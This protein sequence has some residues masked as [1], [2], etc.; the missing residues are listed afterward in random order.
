VVVWLRGIAQDPS[1]LLSEEGRAERAVLNRKQVECVV[2]AFAP[3]AIPAPRWYEAPAPGGEKY[4]VGVAFAASTLAS[5]VEVVGKHPY[6]ERIELDFGEAQR[7]N[8]AVPT[9]FGGCARRVDSVDPKLSK[10]VE[11]ESGGRKPVSVGYATD[12]LPIA[13]MCEGGGYACET[14]VS[15]IWGRAVEAT[16]RLSC[17]LSWLDQHLEGAPANGS[18]VGAESFGATPPLPPFGVVP[19]VKS[20]DAFELTWSEALALAQDEYVTRIELDPSLT[21]IGPDPECVDGVINFPDPSAACD[22]TTEA[23]NGKFLL[24]D[25]DTWQEVPAAK[26]EVSIIVRH[27]YELCPIAPCL[28]NTDTCP[29][30]E[31]AKARVI[32]AATASQTCLRQFIQDIG[33]TA[34]TEVLAT[35]NIV[36]ASL[37]WEQ[38]QQVAR[39]KDVSNIASSKSVMPR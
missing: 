18:Q 20:L 27:R 28:V 19:S 33:G 22:N 39:R 6:V 5:N 36:Y 34:S 21:A 30:S 9:P 15:S 35:G 24:E 25:E 38:I 10:A 8:L 2:S 4:P 32:A 17:A 16:R 7:L 26:H 14:S 1:V 12:L 11:L 23:L 37:T 3:G 13:R 31:R 29:E